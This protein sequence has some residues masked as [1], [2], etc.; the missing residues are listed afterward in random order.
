MDKA[1]LTARYRAVGWQVASRSRRLL[2]M[3]CDSS[4]QDRSSCSAGTSSTW[5][6]S[7]NEGCIYIAS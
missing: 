4:S 5:K 3:T 1:Y 7:H 2:S 6:W